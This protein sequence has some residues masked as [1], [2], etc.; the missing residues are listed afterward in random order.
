M[1]SISSIFVL[2][3]SL[4]TVACSNG[5][6]DAP[7]T[8]SAAQTSASHAVAR[9]VSED[10]AAAASALLHMSALLLDKANPAEAAPFK[11]WVVND[12][13]NTFVERDATGATFYFDSNIAD[14]DAVLGTLQLVVEAK[15]IPEEGTRYTAR[16]GDGN[17][18]KT[19][20][21]L[22]G[23]DARIAAPIAGLARLAIYAPTNADLA[24]FAQFA[25][26]DVSLDTMTVT[27]LPHG[28]ATFAL[29]GNIIEDGD[30]IAGKATMSVTERH[31][32]A[33]P[34]AVLVFFDAKTTRKK[35]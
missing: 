34:E 17:V 6:T 10:A 16:I 32:N 1:K 4:V 26:Y 31:E 28:D 19:A 24:Q 27:E 5:S 8:T 22:T 33:N 35:F 30:I 13:T 18:P 3:F 20:K 23:I 11:Q 25:S 15:S 29:E 7:S 21:S 2:G 9:Q 12:P 14:G